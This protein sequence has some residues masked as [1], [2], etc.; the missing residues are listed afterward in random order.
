M[1]MELDDV[2]AVVNEEVDKIE[3]WLG[4]ANDRTETVAAWLILI[5]RGIGIIKEDLCQTYKDDEY[6]QTVL[7]DLVALVAMG[8]CCLEQY[9]HI[10]EESCPWEHDFSYDDLMEIEEAILIM[11]D[12]IRMAIHNYYHDETDMIRSSLEEIKEM[13]ILGISCLLQHGSV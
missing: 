8:I 6:P 1:A 9:T 3:E 2:I 12:R 13:V 7:E 11:G 5:E 10:Y 4:I